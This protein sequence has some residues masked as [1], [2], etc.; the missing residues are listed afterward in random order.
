M[1]S[2]DACPRTLL[3]TWQRPD[4]HYAGAEAVRKI[5][6]MLPR[7]RIRW[8]YLGPESNLR[9]DRFPPCASFEPRHV[10]WRLRNTALRYWYE[11]HW[12]AGALARRI[13]AWARPLDPQR[14]WVLAELGAVPVGRRLQSMLRVPLHVTVH[15]AYE[16]G[17]MAL[18]RRYYPTYRRSAMR[19]LG[20]CASL[21]AISPEL[22]GRLAESCPSLRSKPSCVFPSSIRQ[23]DMRADV[24]PADGGTKAVRRIA[25]CG[26]MRIDEWQWVEFLALLG[27]LPWSFEILAFVD[28]QAFFRAARPPNV[29]IRFQPYAPSEDAL[30]RQL[31]AGGVW[32]CY[33]GVSRAAMDEAFSLY[34]FSS[35]LTAYSAAG[36]PSIVDAPAAS[37]VWRRVREFDAGLHYDGS[38][39]AAGRLARFFGDAAERARLG[40][41]AVRL[42]HAGMDMDR[43][44]RCFVNLLAQ[45]AGRELR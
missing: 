5:V 21:D 30:V 14:V 26:S 34:S 9:M 6:D 29:S 16:F 20:A 8:A 42:C 37:A 43:N 4:G 41:G 45:D 23:P 11:Q 15:D 27:S 36:L 10:H 1:K 24:P 3:L 40:E 33:L 22:I 12:Q 39:A 32:A 19:L 7:D 25:L 28:E 35:K 44:V 2:V 17:Q 18:P 13:A 31:A 38:A